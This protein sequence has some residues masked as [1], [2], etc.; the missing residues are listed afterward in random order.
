MLIFFTKQLDGRIGT[1][2]RGEEEA[3]VF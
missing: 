2:K 3:V 1:A